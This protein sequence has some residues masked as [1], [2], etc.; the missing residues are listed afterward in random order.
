MVK[1][2]GRGSVVHRMRTRFW[3]A[4]AACVSCQPQA[5]GERQAASA[6][7]SHPMDA[8]RSSSVAQSPPPHAAKPTIGAPTVGTNPGH[9][10]DG[11]ALAPLPGHELA[12]FA[13]G[14]FWGAENT[15]R[16]V[17]GVVA[18]AVGYTGGRTSNPTYESVSS[19][20]TGHAETVLIEFDPERVTYAQLL[21]RFWQSHDPTTKDRQG[22]DVGDN[23]RSAIFTFSVAQTRAARAS[24]AAMQR[25]LARPI[26][27]E[28][29]PIGHFY[30][31]E[32]YHQQYDER[33]GVESC[34]LPGAG[35]GI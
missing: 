27:T 9:V 21:D 8:A 20:R 25:R 19:H 24:M 3:L 13:E 5:S 26:T 6:M 2:A 32:G 31:A 15:F 17:P 12:A 23:Y 29:S 4:F 28:I 11:G 30:V 1:P 14:C 34:P 18:T 22:P 7:A 35:L 16:H 10:K 33:H